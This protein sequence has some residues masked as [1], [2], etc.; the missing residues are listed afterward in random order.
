MGVELTWDLDAMLSGYRHVFL[1]NLSPLGL[2][3]RLFRLLNPGIVPLL[4]RNHFDAVI[5]MAGW[6]TATSLLAVAT[7]HLRGIPYLLYGDASFVPTEERGL[8]PRMRRAFMRWL[9]GHAAGCMVL[10]TMNA[11]YYRHYGARPQQLF[12]MPYAV[13]NERFFAASRLTP[14]ERH[15]VRARYGASRDLVLIA[16]SGKLIDLKNPGHLLDALERMTE[17]GRAGVV[18]IGD[19]PLRER[20][21]IEARARGLKNVFFA[22]FVNQKELPRFLGSADVFVLP[23]SRDQRGTVVNEAMACGLPVVITDGVGI[24]G[25]GDIVRNGDNGFVYPVGD[26]DQLSDI[27]DRLTADAGLRTRMG[28]R[29][30]EIISTWDFDADV[31]GVLHAL[32]GVAGRGS[33]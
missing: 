32:R 18:Y 4:C 33:A 27:L 2:H 7:C 8:R 15:E 19:G 20:L 6:G 24:Y 13:D 28:E 10:G 12:F 30:R 26:V 23:S 29:S 25:E 21:E 11:D 9:V 5:V 3:R 16:F 14:A 17:H 31:E 22:G 1:K